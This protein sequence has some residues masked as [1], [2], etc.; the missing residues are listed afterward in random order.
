MD[1]EQ[2]PEPE[3]EHESGPGR[4]RQ[5]HIDPG[6]DSIHI[7]SPDVE[8]DGV[9]WVQPEDLVP[10]TAPEQ[11]L[12]NGI[13][14][15]QRPTQSYQSHL[16]RQTH[17]DC[18][19]VGSRTELISESQKGDIDTG[20]LQVWGRENEVDAQ[21]Q[22]SEASARQNQVKVPS[23][24]QPLRTHH[25]TSQEKQLLESF[26]ETYWEYCYAWCPVLDRAT[27]GEEME[28]SPLL[29][30]ALATA[31]SHLQPPLIAHRGPAE[32]YKTA[33]T[34]FYDDQEPNAL[35]TLKSLALFYWWA[36]RSPTVV[37]RHSSWWWTSVLIR[38]AQQMNLHREPAP[39]SPM[40]T[41][42]SLSLRR[43]I[44]WTAFVSYPALN[45]SF[46]VSS[47]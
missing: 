22:A 26:V 16:S 46:N 8:D 27:V 12:E 43:R 36:P 35:T 23:P 24:Q 1:R 39:N 3:S 44:W 28:R 21:K 32:Y 5:V 33:R 25:S 18:V 2:E 11:Q 42:L 30:N 38:H 14:P 7:A 31:A 15:C 41:H 34:I 45:T 10:S 9:P 4:E 17:Q 19:S 20:F 29:T 47:C 13:S 6:L 37:H 40:R